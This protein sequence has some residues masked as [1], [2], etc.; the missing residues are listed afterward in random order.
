MVG[1]T[2]NYNTY[3]DWCRATNS[4]PKNADNVK[5]FMESN[6]YVSDC[7]DFYT[8]DEVECTTLFESGYLVREDGGTEVWY[9][10][11]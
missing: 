2:K 1:K 10:N 8:D 5:E 7:G 4:N 3:L 9:V 6:I 11:N